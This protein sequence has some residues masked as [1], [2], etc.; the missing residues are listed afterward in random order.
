MVQA[1]ELLT[2]ELSSVS[3]LSIATLLLGLGTVDR[4]AEEEPGKVGEPGSLLLHSQ[5]FPGT[6]QSTCL[7]SF[8]NH[9]HMESDSRVQIIQSVLENDP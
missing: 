9:S 6:S 1:P 7:D 5:S 2:A 4:R 3:L 8:R